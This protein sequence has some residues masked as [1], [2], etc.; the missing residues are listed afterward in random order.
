M[1]APIIS[2]SPSGTPPPRTS[3]RSRRASIRD[4]AGTT[5]SQTPPITRSGCSLSGSLIEDTVVAGTPVQTT[6][7][8][9]GESAGRRFGS[10]HV[11]RITNRSG[12]PAISIHV[13]APALTTMTRYRISANG[14]D[15][16][17]VEQ[18]SVQW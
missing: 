8:E 17:V 9:F 16:A 5:G 13:Y 3:G 4:S 12:H 15:V 18:A 1:P 2:P 7:R 10:R 14:L 6:A 11:H